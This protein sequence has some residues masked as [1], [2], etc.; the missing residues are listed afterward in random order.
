MTFLPTLWPAS[1]FLCNKSSARN[2]RVRYPGRLL[3]RGSGLACLCRLI[4]WNSLPCKKFRANLLAAAKASNREVS[5]NGV[6]SHGS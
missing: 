4:A 3:G 2:F 5:A 1:V 6:S